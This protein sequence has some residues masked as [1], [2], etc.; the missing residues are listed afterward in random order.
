M[1]GCDFLTPKPEIVEVDL[2]ADPGSPIGCG[3]NPVNG[4]QHTIL[5]IY[6]KRN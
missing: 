4:L 6:E 2:R 3:A 1:I 5:Q